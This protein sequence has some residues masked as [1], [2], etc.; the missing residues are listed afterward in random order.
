MIL[1]P[2]WLALRAGNGVRSERGGEKDNGEVEI[3]L[4]IKPGVG[5][6]AFVVSCCIF[7]RD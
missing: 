7:F 6:L 2:G 4:H 1:T 3:E 5:R